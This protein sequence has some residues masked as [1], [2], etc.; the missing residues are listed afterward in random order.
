[1][2]ASVTRRERL[3]MAQTRERFAAQVNSEILPAVRALAKKEGRQLQALVNEAFVDLIEK[4]KNATPRARV[5]GVPGQPR[6]IRL[7]V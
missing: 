3:R 1:M 7:A 5:I 6:K 4:R 2:I